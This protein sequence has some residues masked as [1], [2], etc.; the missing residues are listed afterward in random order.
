MNISIANEVRIFG[1]SVLCGILGGVVFDVFRAL[2]IKIKSGTAV[3]ALEDILFWLVLSGIVFACIY[4]FNNGQLRWYIFLG[5][6]LGTIMYELTISS[7][8]VAMFKKL[9]DFLCA[10]FKILK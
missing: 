8:I 5:I 9:L 1:A 6:L 2:R 10:V 4:R 3:V 7:Y